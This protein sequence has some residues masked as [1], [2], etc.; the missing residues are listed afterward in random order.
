MNLSAKHVRL[1]LRL[2]QPLF[3]L[4]GALL[5]SLGAAIASFLGK[6]IDLYLYLLGQ[7]LVTSLQLMTHFLLVYH[8][9]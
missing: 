2:S 8:E 6:P 5:Y 9:P 3:L 7:G 4:G 1:F